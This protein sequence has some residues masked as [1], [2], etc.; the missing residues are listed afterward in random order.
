VV[1]FNL[2]LQAKTLPPYLTNI[3]ACNACNGKLVRNDN[4]PVG[5]REETP[6]MSQLTL[7]VS[8]LPPP[9]PME[10]I[11][12]ALADMPPGDWLDVTLSR[13]PQPLYGI[14]RT[15]DYRWHTTVRAPGD[16]QVV[17]WPAGQEPPLADH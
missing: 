2:S 12:D 14:L 9:E 5:R 16:V 3:K 13:D 8:Q 10:R 17:I 15:M 4:R 6:T 11:L 1:R 7:D